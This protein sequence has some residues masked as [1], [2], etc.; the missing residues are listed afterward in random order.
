MDIKLITTNFKIKNSVGNNHPV[1]PKRKLKRRFMDIL[2]MYI[3]E[4]KENP[5]EWYR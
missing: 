3:V 1:F 4:E 5:D 2:Y